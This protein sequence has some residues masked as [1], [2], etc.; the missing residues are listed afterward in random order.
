MEWLQG[1]IDLCTPDEVVFCD[2]SKKQYNKIANMLVKAGVFIKLDDEKKPNS[3]AVRSDVGDVARV[4]ERTFICSKTKEEAGP[5]NN[6][7]DPV[8]MRAILCGKQN[9]LY[10]GCMKGR[11]MYVIPF[12]MG[13][14]DS[15][16]SKYGIELTDSG[17]VV[18]NMN[19][20]TRVS[21]KILERI[22]DGTEFVKCV[23]SVGAPLNPGDEIG[24]AHV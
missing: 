13:P 12:S 20:M 23:H 6:W 1:W 4:E 17:Y 3:Y 9:G 16:I 14:V 21:P 7:C 11:T 24:R 8:E 5:T 2:G 10:K 18:C 15:P 19:I 22:D